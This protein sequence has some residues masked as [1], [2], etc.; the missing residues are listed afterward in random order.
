MGLTRDEKFELPSPVFMRPEKPRAVVTQLNCIAELIPV[1]P[2]RSG[3]ILRRNERSCYFLSAMN[4]DTLNPRFVFSSFLRPNSPVVAHVDRAIEAWQGGL[5]ASTA[6]VTIEQLAPLAGAHSVRVDLWVEHLDD[7]SC[8]YGFL[9]SSEDGNT[10]YAR[11]ERV[12]ASNE[13]R[14][15]PAFRARVST[16][17]KDLPAYA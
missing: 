5:D 9:C 1:D 12:I 7:W 15:S 4:D 14:W 13:G 8:V 2:P 10:A 6:G 3:N 11:G 16:L 17:L